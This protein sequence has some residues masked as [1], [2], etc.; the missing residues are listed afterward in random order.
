MRELAW[1]QRTSSASHRYAV[2]A[3]IRD[4]LVGYPGVDPTDAMA[5]RDELL[6][7][8]KHAGEAPE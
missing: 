5:M 4:D 2:H 3:A 7:M 6:G 1:S 8:L